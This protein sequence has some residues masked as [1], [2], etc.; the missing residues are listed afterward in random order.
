MVMLLRMLYNKRKRGNINYE[1]SYR[2][3]VTGSLLYFIAGL[4][5]I[6]CSFA[7]NYSSAINSSGIDFKIYSEICRMYLEAC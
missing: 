5:P 2:I 4:L 7:K 1:E 6:W 3:F